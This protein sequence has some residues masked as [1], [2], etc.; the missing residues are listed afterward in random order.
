MDDSAQ[1]LRSDWILLVILTIAAGLRGASAV[2]VPYVHC[3]DRELIPWSQQISWQHLPIREWQ[4]PALPAYLIKASSVLFGKTRLGFR[5]MSLLAGIS[6]IAA[7]YQIGLEW[8]GR[9]T[10]RW[11]ALLLAVNEYHIAISAKAMDLIFDLYFITLAMYGFSRFL[12]TQRPAWLYV[13]GVST[14]LG[15]LC[16]EITCLML[17]VFFVTLLLLPHRR[18]LCRKEPWLAAALFFAIIFPDIWSNLQVTAE[19]R[20]PY[21]IS[22]ADHFS[23]FAG[24][25]LSS[26]PWVFY[27][28][29]VLDWASIPY[30]DA[31]GDLPTID[32]VFAVVLWLGVALA[33]LQKN[34]SS[35]TVFSLTMF[36]GI[37]GFF[38]LMATKDPTRD[39]ALLDPVLW[40]WVDR[41][42][43]PASLLAG[44][45]L[46]RTRGKW[47]ILTY[48]A[49]A[50][51]VLYAF[52]RIG[53][54]LP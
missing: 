17:P 27:F 34:K 8:W 2:N 46:A 15:F 41:T 24:F 30:Y 1:R 42:M 50:T 52:V 26:Q 11:A 47:R 31:Q 21:Y 25:G 18:W 49:A 14:G 45:V 16:K 10:A 3:E 38:A 44:N 48:I 12:K 43:L 39:D 23:R 40:Y 36:W 35:L 7:I 22:Y 20:S 29:D 4:H 9:S 6:C 5:M 33:T 32:P 53:E 54:L 37:F 51:S 28:A 13:A 19:T